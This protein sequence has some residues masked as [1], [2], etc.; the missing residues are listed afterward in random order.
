MKINDVNISDKIYGAD[1][2]VLKGNTNQNMP[3][4]VKN[5]LVEVPPELI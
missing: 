4:P 3:T 5:Y 1:I 2:S